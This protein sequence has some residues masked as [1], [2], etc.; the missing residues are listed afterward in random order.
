[1]GNKNDDPLHEL[2]SNAA[3]MQK[4]IQKVLG[5]Q[6]DKLSEV[7]AKVEYPEKKRIKLKNK[8]ATM[9]LAKDKSHVKIEFDD[10]SDNVSFYEGKKK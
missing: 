4:D 7:M 3:K 6:M 10:I 1:M 5:S 8:R 2:R 9:F